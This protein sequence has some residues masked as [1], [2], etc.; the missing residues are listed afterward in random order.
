MRFTNLR[1]N[2]MQRQPVGLILHIGEKKTDPKKPGKGRDSFRADGHYA[3]RF[4]SIYGKIPQEVNVFFH[5][6]DLRKVAQVFKEYRNSGGVTLARITTDWTL[7]DSDLKQEETFEVFNIKKQNWVE[8]D[9]EAFDA[10][11]EGHSLS[12]RDTLRLF[13][14]VQE[15]MKDRIPTVCQIETRGV[16][17]SIPSILN[18]LKLYAAA[19]KLQIPF[20]LIVSKNNGK[21]IDKN[22][23]N[24]GK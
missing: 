1:N 6:S 15:F 4:E 21:G 12:A 20:K 16:E 13:F 3:A 19:G 14:M 17:S 24:F 11:V 22:E 2:T 10:F 23:K 9:E 8:T 5:S 7:W 18:T